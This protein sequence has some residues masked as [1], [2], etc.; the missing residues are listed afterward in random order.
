[1]NN[2]QKSIINEHK[3]LVV[4]IH[5][6]DYY[7]HCEGGKADSKIEYANKCIQL[8]AMKKYAEALAARLFSAG[9]IFNG[10]TYLEPV[11]QI[12]ES[13][14]DYLMYPE[15]SNDYDVDARNCQSTKEP[16]TT[17]CEIHN[18]DNNE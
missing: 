14:A 7:V 10:D 18:L 11:D 17:T 2:Y 6:L 8:S 16:E 9:I 3:E 4:R 15:Q 13:L 5:Q 12:D 1:M